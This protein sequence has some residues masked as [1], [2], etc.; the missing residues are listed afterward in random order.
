MSDPNPTGDLRRVGRDPAAFE[1]FYRRHVETVGRFVARR[2][3]DPH[4]A[5]DL[6]AEVFVAVIESADRY[7]P[8]LGSER[9]WLFG[10]ARNVIAAEHRRVARELRATG[11]AAGRR[12]LDPDD[13]V[14]LEERID[15]EAAARRTYQALRDVPEKTRALLELVGVDGLPVA[16]AAS[17]LGMSPVAARVRLHRARRLV[18]LVLS[19]PESVLV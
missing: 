2:V 19:R 4:T 1:V 6:T 10:V 16:E 15:A 11:R 14:R 12:Q 8:D 3:D 13:V 18:R 17:A 9:G 5:A 7:R